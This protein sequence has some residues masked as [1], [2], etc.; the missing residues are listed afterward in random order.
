[1]VTVPA[2]LNT[3]DPDD[4]PGATPVAR[5]L[6][7]AAARRAWADEHGWP[8]GALSRLRE[9]HAARRRALGQTPVDYDE[10]VGPRSDLDD[11]P[12]MSDRR[13]RTLP[14]GDRQC[15]VP[16]TASRRARAALAPSRRRTS[17]WPG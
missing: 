13:R 14:S 12:R 6:A 9:E 3:F 17:A 5:V 15:E 7:W 11:E 10:V 8:R 2:H 1:M 16:P 4:W